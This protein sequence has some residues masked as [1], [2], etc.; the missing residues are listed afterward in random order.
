MNVLSLELTNLLNECLAIK[1]LYGRMGLQALCVQQDE[2][3]CEV[4]VVLRSDE[5]PYRTSVVQW[6]EWRFAN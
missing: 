3:P 6:D 4:N 5:W 2:W 1:W